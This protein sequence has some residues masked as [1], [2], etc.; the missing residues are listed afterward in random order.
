MS[1]KLYK[2]DK[3]YY[4][5]CS[6]EKALLQYAKDGGW[7]SIEDLEGETGVTREEFIGRWFLVSHSR[8][9]TK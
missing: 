5:F 7:D 1:R 3:E 9:F 6:N 4:C 2:T 8:V